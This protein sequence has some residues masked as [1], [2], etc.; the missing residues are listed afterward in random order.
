MKRTIMSMT[1][2]VASIFV[3][4]LVGNVQA[5]EQCS[6]A[7]LQ[8]DY[9]VTGRS[10]P[11]GYDHAAGGFPA[12]FIAVWIFDEGNISGFNT[13]SLGGLIR[14]LPVNGTY[15]LDPDRDCAYTLTFGVAQVAYWDLFVTRDGSEG[16]ALRTDDGFIATRYIKKR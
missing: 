8:G 6:L 2:V 10:D 11:P 1:L 14:R 4:G 5:Q 3:L 16:A 13:Q 7:T 12:S 9:L 15:E